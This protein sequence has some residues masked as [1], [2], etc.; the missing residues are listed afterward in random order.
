MCVC[1]GAWCLMLRCKQSLQSTQ[2]HCTW[3]TRSGSAMSSRQ[4]LQLRHPS[5]PA[6]PIQSVYSAVHTRGG[7]RGVA[8]PISPPPEPF[9]G[10]R[11]HPLGIKKKQKRYDIYPR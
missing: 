3:V 9:R 10:W 2:L 8:T 1:V 4:M 7:F 5:P 11:R 6:T